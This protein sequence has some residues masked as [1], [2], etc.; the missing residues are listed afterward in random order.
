MEAISIGLSPNKLGSGYKDSKYL[1][2]AVVSKII[3]SS[4]NFKAGT[5]ELGAMALYSG[6]LC[7]SFPKSKSMIST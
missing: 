6:V 5:L 3:V 7:S 2:I 4:S 1:Q